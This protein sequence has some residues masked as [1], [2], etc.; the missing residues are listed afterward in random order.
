MSATPRLPPH[1]LCSVFL[2]SV[3]GV[4]LALE[5]DIGHAT[6]V[7]HTKRGTELREAFGPGD[8]RI[9]WGLRERPDSDEL[10]VLLEMRSPENA[11]IARI[12]CCTDDPQP[13]QSV[14]FNGQEQIHVTSDLDVACG[15]IRDVVVELRMSSTRLRDAA[16]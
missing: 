15:W 11:L 7:S 12:V 3:E 10:D 13:Y 2:D 5:I 8:S 9:T 1:P 14:R 16:P 6:V 4:L